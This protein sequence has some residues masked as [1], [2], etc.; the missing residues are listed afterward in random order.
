M[1]P[2]HT[3][4]EEMDRRA[5]QA[6]N[7]PRGNGWRHAALI[8]RLQWGVSRMLAQLERHARYFRDEQ[9]EKAAA[10]REAAALLTTLTGEQ[11]AAPESFPDLRVLPPMPLEL[12]LF[13]PAGEHGLCTP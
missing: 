6:G 1:D 11:A 10:Y 4:L 13:D 9:P 5:K 2:I 3:A 7:C 8:C 12:N